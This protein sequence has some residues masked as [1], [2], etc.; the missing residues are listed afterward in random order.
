MKPEIQ[1]LKALEAET[2]KMQEEA[3]AS[4]K[5]KLYAIFE[6]RRAEILNVLSVAQA[7]YADPHTEIEAV[8]SEAYVR[9]SIKKLLADQNYLG[10]HQ[11]H[12][13]REFLGRK[14][15]ND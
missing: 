13:E 6:F 8:K 7:L 1:V 14:D 11:K 15:W 10:G 3:K 9:D 4:G 2:A 12:F 5:G